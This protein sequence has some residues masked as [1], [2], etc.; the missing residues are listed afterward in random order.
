[1]A[2]PLE[3]R[4]ESAE[5]PAAVP[6]APD[7][8]RKEVLAAASRVDALNGGNVPADQQDALR[9]MAREAAGL[10]PDLQ[11]EFMDFARIQG[12][13]ADLADARLTR[14]FNEARGK[15]LD[16][17]VDPLPDLSRID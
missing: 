10:P 12:V 7:A 6:L 17:V 13:G 8:A 5:R 9:E 1:M 15:V 3:S 4:N 14:G 16:D 2:S 11:R